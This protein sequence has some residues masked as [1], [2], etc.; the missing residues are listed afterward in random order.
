M[1]TFSRK[2]A[3][4][5]GAEI[6]RARRR[7]EFS[8]N[9]SLASFH[10]DRYLRHT[11]RRLEHLASLRIPVAGRRVLELGA[12]VGDHTTYYLDRGCDVT[13]TEARA[14]NIAVLRSRFPRGKIILMD[15]ENP[16]A[17]EGSPF[18]V[19]HCYGLLYH[20]KNPE[21]ALK[22][23]SD[24]CA[25]MLFLETCVSFGVEKAVNLV[26]EP[27]S[28]PTQSFSGTGCRPTRPWIYDKLKE[29]FPYV[30]CPVTQPN[31]EEFPLDWN[32]PGCA[33]ESGLH[34][35]VFVASKA[36]IRN[37]MLSSKLLDVQARQA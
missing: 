23:V 33:E 22:Y 24:S 37:E 13:L 1:K 11:A 12:G 35:A 10:S 18:D 9:S 19:V 34:R 17:L 2:I 20:L 4:M 14:E 15:A 29:G 7:L 3:G 8:R 6:V 27:T 16:E 30:Y 28:D 5:L 32:A 25:G 36:E 26:E 31:H 21:R